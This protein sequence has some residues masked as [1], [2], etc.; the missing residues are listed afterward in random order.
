[1]KYYV[2]KTKESE[3]FILAAKDD[4]D[5][6]RFCEQDD[7]MVIVMRIHIN[8]MSVIKTDAVWTEYLQELYETKL[9]A[10]S[11]F[12]IAATNYNDVLSEAPKHIREDFE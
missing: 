3:E 1:M 10:S 8:N 5:A 4:G 12:S 6:S 7:E 2:L 9:K 11:A